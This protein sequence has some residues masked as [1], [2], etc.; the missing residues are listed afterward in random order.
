M[1]ILVVGASGVTGSELIRYLNAITHEIDMDLLSRSY[2]G[3]SVRSIDPSSCVTQKK[4]YIGYSELSDVTSYDFIFLCISAQDAKFFYEKYLRAVVSK[5][6]TKVIDL[7]PV[8]R[9]KNQGVFEDI[10]K[11]KRPDIDIGNIAI[12]V[13]EL[14][15]KELQNAQ[16]ISPPGCIAT[17]CI[18][19]LSPIAKD[20][21][22]VVNINALTSFSGSGRTPKREKLAIE[23]NDSL[24]TYKAFSHRHC[25]EV[26]QALN[27]HSS[28]SWNDRVNITATSVPISRGILVN[29]F[30]ILP[31]YNKKELKNLYKFFYQDNPLVTVLNERSRH[32]LQMPNPKL[33]RGS[34]RVVIGIEEGGDG[35]FYI[36][37]AIDNL[38]RGSAGQAA[39]I[40][41]NLLGIDLNESFFDSPVAL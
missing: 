24:R 16:I 3:L 28:V 22:G 2:S 38:G 41:A 36:S 8:F 32:G 9:L 25:P 13:P 40:F 14:F 29:T 33:V 23:V 21:S 10:Y 19:M 20:M 7:S 30:I 35:S 26:E 27:M 37:T 34:C 12:G 1:K 17:A 5:C 4:K 6:N 11:F 15:G 39:L 18:F 31:G